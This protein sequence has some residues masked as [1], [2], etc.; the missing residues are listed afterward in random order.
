[1]GT[2]PEDLNDISRAPTV[3]LGLGSNLGDRMGNLEKAVEHLCQKAVI[4]RASSV[5]ETEP[6]GYEDQPL[7]LNAVISAVTELEP[8]E[9][10][11]FV[12]KIETELGRKQGFRNAPRIIDIDILFYGNMIVRS[13]EL[14][15]PH[16]GIAERAFVLVPLAEIAPEHFHPMVG[17]KIGDLLNEVSGIDGVKRTGRM[18]LKEAIG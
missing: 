18:S 9:L 15:I 14:T 7:F 10:L 4:E 17:R 2:K 5:Y 3:Y 13:Q 1:M 16:P 8:F 11:C 6:V 12:K